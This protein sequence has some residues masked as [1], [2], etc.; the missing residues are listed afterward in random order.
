VDGSGTGKF[1]RENC[2]H[3]NPYRKRQE[4]AGIDLVS[5]RFRQDP[6]DGTIV[7][8]YLLRNY[9]YDV[10]DLKERRKIYLFK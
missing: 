1:R 6:L 2:F 4:L 8:G 7:L 5:S 9:F 3:S 10:I